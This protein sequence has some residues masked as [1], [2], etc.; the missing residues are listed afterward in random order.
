MD[1]YTQTNPDAVLFDHI[2][3]SSDYTSLTVPHSLDSFFFF[4]QNPVPHMQAVA[5]PLSIFCVGNS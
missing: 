3:A 1:Q 4:F 2:T 5:F